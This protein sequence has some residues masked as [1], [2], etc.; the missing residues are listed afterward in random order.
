MANG[1]LTTF[2]QILLL[3]K[4]RFPCALFSNQSEI[5]ISSLG[6]IWSCHDFSRSFH[7]LFG[8]FHYAW[9]ATQMAFVEFYFLR[10]K[11]HSSFF[12]I[13]SANNNLTAK[14]HRLKNRRH[15]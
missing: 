14:H 15:I 3:M 4:T 8:L 6:Y 1:A 13:I 2:N 10:G 11:Y 7:R 9:R 5:T 12:A